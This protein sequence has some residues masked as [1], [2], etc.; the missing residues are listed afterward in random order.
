MIDHYAL[1]IILLGIL[2]IGVWLYFSSNGKK[3]MFAQTLGTLANQRR[4]YSKC[5]SDCFRNHENLFK[6]NFSG[7]EL[8]CHQKC[9]IDSENRSIEKVPDLSAN[10]FQRHYSA[11]NKSD[12]PELDYCLEDIKDNCNTNECVFSK[13]Q[14]ECKKACLKVNQYKCFSGLSWSSSP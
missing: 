11:I 2:S 7:M 13:N 5:T 9:T 6:D 3:E 10:E 14:E 4:Y 12:N 1:P 8:L